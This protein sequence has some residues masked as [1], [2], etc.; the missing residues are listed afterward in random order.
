MSATS[1]AKAGAGQQGGSR[2]DNI[3][4]D[5]LTVMKRKLVQ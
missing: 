5:E 4:G 3:Q 2:T 1:Q